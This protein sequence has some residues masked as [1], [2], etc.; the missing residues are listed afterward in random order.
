MFHISIV[1]T[2]KHDS[3]EYTSNIFHYFVRWSSFIFI[4]SADNDPHFMI[5]IPSTDINVCF[6]I[7]GKPGDIVNLMNDP[8]L[9]KFSM[10]LWP[11][12]RGSARGGG[13]RGAIFLLVSSAVG[14][15]HDNTPTP[16]WSRSSSET[17]CPPPPKQT[18]WRRP[19]RD[20]IP[21]PP[22]FYSPI[23]ICSSSSHGNARVTIHRKHDCT[24]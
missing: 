1:K 21:P 3:D 22:Q 23:T 9:G 20:M 12:H 14:H 11:W 17:S 16:L 8:V 4:L 2:I 7:T 18:P 13:G 5:E 19:C 15:G 10:T 6:D 24:L